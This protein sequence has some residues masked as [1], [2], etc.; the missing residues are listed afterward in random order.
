M[1]VYS[2]KSLLKLRKAVG[3]TIGANMDPSHL[4]VMGMDPIACVRALKGVIYHSHGKDACFQ[5]GVI[6]TKGLLEQQPVT[7]INHRAWNYVAVGAGHNLQYWREF[8]ATLGMMGYD[9]PV[10][11]EMEDLSMSVEQGMEESISTLKQAIIK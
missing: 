9:G 1:L 4:F 2:P 3:P 8:Y 10:S 5:R 11:L 7:D 6:E